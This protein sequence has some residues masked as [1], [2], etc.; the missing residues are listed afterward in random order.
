[1]LFAL[2][3]LL[4]VLAGLA[5]WRQPRMMAAIFWSFLT[6]AL[7]CATLLQILPG[8]FKEVALTIAIM[9][10]AIWVALIIQ[11]AW[12]RHI[13]RVYLVQGALCLINILFILSLGDAG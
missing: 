11:T 7:T 1:M 2:V 3:F 8:R 12:D 4:L 9:M 10:P 5:S 13:G 6:M